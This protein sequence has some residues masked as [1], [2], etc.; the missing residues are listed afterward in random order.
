MYNYLI[1]VEGKNDAVFIKDYISYLYNN[2]VLEKD[3]PKEKILK[4][5]TIVIKI[6]VAG[7]YTAISKYLRI[8]LEELNDQ[9]FKIL[10]I[11]DADDPVK[12]KENGGVVLRKKYLNNIQSELSV[13]FNT[14]L[15]PNNNSDGDI[16]TL[17]LKIVNEEKHQN[18]FNCYKSYVDCISQI[19]DKKHSDELLEAKHKVFC[20]IRTYNGVHNAKEE[21]RNFNN[22]FWDLSNE[23]LNPLKNFFNDCFA[24]GNI[25]KG[26]Q[27]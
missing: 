27:I 24:L 5:D 25:Y 16:E 9:K 8:R 7:G 3:L 11:Q 17:L 22:E 4:N 15:F 2:V 19:A 13:E 6:L 1:I 21:N 20:Y 10:I 23:E 26:V 14:F 12:D 18:S